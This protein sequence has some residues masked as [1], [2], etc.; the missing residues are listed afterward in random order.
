MRRL[1]R[2]MRY[3]RPFIGTLLTLLGDGGRYL[4]YRWRAPAALTAE[5]RFLRKQLALYC[6]RNIKPRRATPATRIA[7]L[8]LPHCFDWRRALA[9]V[10][11][12]TL[13]QSGF[14]R[15]EL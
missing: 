7:L 1:M 4:M 2:F 9:I 5:N 13:R 3:L 15:G 11:P 12:Q 6:E 14:E 8:W 10:R